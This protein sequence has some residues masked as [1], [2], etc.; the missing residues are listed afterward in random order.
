VMDVLRR[1]SLNETIGAE[2][3]FNTEDAALEAIFARVTDGAFDAAA[4]PLRRQA[5]TP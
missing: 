5:V 4:C 3:F 1:T 2:N